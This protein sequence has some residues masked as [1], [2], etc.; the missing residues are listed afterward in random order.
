MTNDIYNACKDAAEKIKSFPKKTRVRVVSHYDADGISA[1]AIICKTLYRA[2]Y[3]FHATLMRNP[4]DKGLVRI[5]KEENEIVIYSD[6]G[7][8]QIETIE[9]MKNQSI[10]FDH[11]QPQKK[12]TK[13]NVLQINCNHFGINGNYEACGSTIAYVFA[14]SFDK[15]NTDLASLAIT[16][17]TGDKQYIGGFRELNKEIIEKAVQN[18][19]V[20]KKTGIKLSC[21][22]IYDSLYY[23]IDPYYGGISG[24]KEEIEKLLSKFEI[25]KDKKVEHLDYTELK[26]INSYLML[27]LIKKKCEKNILDT[28]IRK[29]YYTN[30]F[31]LESEQLADLFDSC[32][33]GGNRGIGLSLALGDNESLKKAKKIERKYKEKVLDELLRLEKEGFKETDGFRYFYTDRSSIGGVIGG[34]ATNFMLDIKKPLIS[35]V[36]KNDEIHV[37]C[38]G[39]QHLVKKGL[40][41]GFAMRKVA[42]E[43]KGHGGGH[44]IA[45]GAT[46]DSSKE[47]DFLEIVNKIIVNQIGK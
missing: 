22:T 19:V 18:S 46:I 1:A 10:I 41:L 32:G 25:N 5:S 39:N 28:V 7:S 23:S 13:E 42:K 30:I 4:F 9:E 47:K 3:N 31:N 35:I 37:S 34:I 45:S 29:R 43:L 12:Q 20:S 6:M 17:M 21:D 26:K 44:A 15:K 24:N 16:G 2:G 8:G 40:D 33:K 38:R 14:K 11:H 27:T 36:R